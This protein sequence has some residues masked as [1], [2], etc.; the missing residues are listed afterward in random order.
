MTLKCDAIFREKLTGGL[1]K[2]IIWL[3][4]METVENLK[5]CT[6]MGFFYQHHVKFSTKKVQNS[7]LS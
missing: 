7:Y 1:K 4:F 6:F 2:D 5:I 3:L